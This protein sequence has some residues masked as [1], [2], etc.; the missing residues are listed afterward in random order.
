MPID[1]KPQK[2][3]RLSR[4]RY[5]ALVRQ[6]LELRPRCECGCGRPS[7]SAHHVVGRRYGG[8]VEEN[9]MMLNGDGTRGCHGALT[10]GMRTWDGD[11]YI[12]PDRV[13][14]GLRR[15]METSRP[16]VLA[17]AISVKGRDWL[18][19]RYPH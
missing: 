5:N 8:D 10:S 11:A 9:L 15:A 16:D 17:Y 4:A 13:A 18:A 2:P 19:R 3:L 12:E 6:L 1:P 14:A 7:H